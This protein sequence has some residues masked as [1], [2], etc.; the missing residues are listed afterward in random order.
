MGS[1][2]GKNIARMRGLFGLSQKDIADHLG[3]SQS[4]VAGWESGGRSPSSVNL[5]GVAELFNVPVE[6]LTGTA[7]EIPTIGTRIQKSRH[8]G[9]PY[10]GRIHAGDPIEADGVDEVQ[11]V[12]ATVAEK[13]PQ[14]FLL[15]VVGDCMN[16]V[17]PDGARVVVDPSLP[18]GSGDVG[19]FLLDGE[20]VMRRYL[21]GSSVVLL[22]PDSTQPGY[23]DL[24][25]KE[26]DTL[27]CYGRVVWY[28]APREL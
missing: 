21:K 22:S 27:I 18:V 12:P 3:I 1:D 6:K 9:L 5:I 23:E 4:A 14:G 2:I 13:H 11:E 19:A 20:V 7:G 26:G 15:D 28:Q 24:V 10:R 8:A 16:R 25:I 17:F